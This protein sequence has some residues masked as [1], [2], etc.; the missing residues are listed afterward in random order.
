VIGSDQ[1][2]PNRLTI[3]ARAF[4]QRDIRLVEV[5]FLAFNTTEWAT[6]IAILVYA[7]G[8]GGSVAAGTVAVI[9]LV[10]AALFAPFG[11]M[12][13]DLYPREK[14]IFFSYLAQCLAMGATAAALF[15]GA[16]VAVVYACAAATASAITLTRPVQ[17]ALLPMLAS[18][19][20]ELI[21]ANVTAGTIES[22]SIFAGPAFTGFLLAFLDVGAVFAIMAVIELAGALAVGSI[23]FR[24]VQ[25]SR[26]REGA[27]GMWSEL[28]Q[29]LGAVVR[30]TDS[31]LLVGLIATQS[32]EVGALDVL[33]VVLAL[34]VLDL[35]R[36][37]AGFL[38]SAFGVGGVLGSAFSVVLIGR[39][40]L[41]P[42]LLA[43][44][45]AFGVALGAAGLTTTAIVA[46]LLL[47]VCGGGRALVDVTGRSLL[48]RVVPN[49]SLSRAFG[50]LEGLAMAGL[51]VGSILVPVLVTSVGVRLTLLAIGALLPVVAL[52]G[53]PGLKRVDATASV[54]IH[55]LRILRAVPLFSGLDAPVLERLASSLSAVDIPEG[56]VVFRQGDLGDLFYIIEE[57][58]VQVV[59]D[60]EV[61]ERLGA[62]DFFGEI[63]LLRRVP[64]TATIVAATGARLQAL[65]GDVFIEAVTGQPELSRSAEEIVAQR[66]RRE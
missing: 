5:A 51:A 20:E 14:M 15:V 25:A 49:E 12:L 13:S 64:R 56:G 55:A 44:A 31:R 4:R 26:R 59:I 18:T 19:P 45:L 63:A 2:A 58:A 35:G 24:D 38:N 3:L 11:A 7:Y 21:A 8:K 34:T 54:P 40:R 1:T 33:F 30:N 27:T 28:T 46:V 66:L 60:G 10:P 48:Q 43:G 47:G 6:W 32:V 36:P 53:W 41:A 65:D 61:V 16:P 52:L 17:G 29:G 37:G 23:E 39:K 62:S 57:G 50:A 22:V 9:Q 42:H